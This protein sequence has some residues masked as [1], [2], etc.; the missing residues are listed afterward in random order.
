M[1]K[2]SRTPSL[3]SEPRSRSPDSE[4]SV[5][6]TASPDRSK[7]LRESEPVPVSS[8]IMHCSLL[9]HRETLSFASYEDYEVHYHQA[10]VNR[11]SQCSK[12]FPTSHYLE[13]HIEENHD[14]LAVAR[15]DRG[16]KTVSELMPLMSQVGLCH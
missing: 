1:S 14:P 4:S 11:C 13:L 7:I 10:H 15:R 16:E 2:R 6:V 12:N 3:K 9:P 5:T 8:D